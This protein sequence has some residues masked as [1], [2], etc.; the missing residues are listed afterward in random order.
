[1]RQKLTVITLGVSDLEKA[2]EFY[3]QGLGWKKSSASTDDLVLFS[4]GGFALALYP[5]NLLAADASVPAEGRG[6]SG[7]TVSFNAK[8]IKEVDEVL[9][10]VEKVGATIVKPAQKAFWGGYSGYFQDPDGHL[11]EVAYNPFW[12][13]DDNGDLRLPT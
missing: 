3:E 5:R 13:L 4:L 11:I 9:L 7:V 1:M 8:S 10:E 6:F 2:T 12:P